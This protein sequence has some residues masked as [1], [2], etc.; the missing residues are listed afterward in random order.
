MH[1]DAASGDEGRKEVAQHRVVDLPR[2]QHV[3]EE[4][5][6][7]LAGPAELRDVTLANLM[8]HVE[9]RNVVVEALPER[10][11]YLEGTVVREEL[12]HRERVHAKEVVARDARH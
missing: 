3:E 4:D 6:D 5:V 1:D 12:R 9:A 7:R 10:L 2:L 8:R 11:A